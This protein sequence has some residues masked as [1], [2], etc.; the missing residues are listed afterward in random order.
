MYITYDEGYQLTLYDSNQKKQINSI[1]VWN[2]GDW[3][4][5]AWNHDGTKYYFI[6]GFPDM[7]EI[8]FF[9]HTLGTVDGN[10]QLFAKIPKNK[11]GNIVSDLEWSPND[12]YIAFTIGKTYDSGEFVLIDF[13]DKRVIYTGMFVEYYRMDSAS[14]AGNYPVWSPDSRYVAFER[15]DETRIGETVILNVETLEF[16]IIPTNK[17]L[18]GWVDIESE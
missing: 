5:P 4:L 10:I 8:Y 1:P 18:L 12:R 9:Y 17:Q 15:I 16:T 2:S 11:L 13:E 14:H 6:Y 7:D 3:D